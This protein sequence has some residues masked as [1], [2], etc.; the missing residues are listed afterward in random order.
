MCHPLVTI[1]S[2]IFFHSGKSVK[3]PTKQYVTLPTTPKMCCRTTSRNLNVQ[4]C[5]IFCILNCVKIKHSHQTYGGNFI[6]SQLI[7]KISKAVLWVGDVSFWLRTRLLARS[8]I[9]SDQALRR[10]P[11][12]V[13]LLTVLMSLNFSS[14]LLMLLFCLPFVGKFIRYLCHF[15]SFNWC[16]LLI[17]I[18][19]SSL[20]TMFANTAVTSAVM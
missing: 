8:T 9:S 18:L 6:T 4:I 14:S 10:L 17:E 15:M 20:K 2:S 1:I 12:P 19:P 3:F 16:K 13:S 7:I 5:C 11:L